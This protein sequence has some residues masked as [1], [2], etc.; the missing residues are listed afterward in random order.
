[1]ALSQENL[2]RI[3]GL[4]TG[5]AAQVHVNG[6][7]TGR[8]AI[9]RGV[10]QG[11]P[12]APLLFAIVTQPLMRSLREEERCG[13]VKGVAYDGEQTLL[14]QIYADDTGVNI[15][16]AE[17]Q[18]NRLR[19]VIGDYEEVSGAKLN[20]TK[21]LIMPI[22]HVFPPDWALR[23]TGFYPEEHE[24]RVIMEIEEW[25]KTKT[26]VRKELHEVDGW[27]WREGST[28]IRWE[29]ST[30]E[31]TQLVHNKKDF[32]EYLNEKWSR[33]YNITKEAKERVQQGIRT[34]TSRRQN[35][36]AAGEAREEEY[37]SELDSSFCGGRSV[38]EN[39]E[40]ATTSSLS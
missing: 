12:L 25:T 15:T 1:M 11:C 21:S 26:L 33:V 7:F 14:H 40:S 6:Q 16:M 22:M 32:T 5:G 19:E 24:K 39:S 9:T 38:I 3:Q 23:E 37:L 18:F 4:V 29:T 35:R 8:F 31:W 27:V 30:K 13:R 2:G 34:W 10:R 20:L 17:T 28:P 36:A